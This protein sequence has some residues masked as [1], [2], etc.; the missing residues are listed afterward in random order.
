MNLRSTSRPMQA[1]SAEHNPDST[2]VWDPVVRMCHWTIVAG[3]AFNLFRENGGTTHR[4]V[5]YLVSAALAVR[6]FWGFVGRGHARFSKFVPH[7]ATLGKYLRLLYLNREP[8]YLGH[9][10][11]GALMS[12]A[13]IGLLIIVSITGWMFGIERYS[14]SQSLKLIHQISAMSLLPVVGLHVLV[15]VFE[16]LGHH[17]NLIKSMITGR[18]R[19]PTGTDID[20]TIDDE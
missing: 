18:K 16:S 4:A 9:N 15:V 11:A 3:C 10:P 6:L 20:V 2:P 12:L 7:L 1:T 8:R 14:G 13:L 19:K 17:E 5:G